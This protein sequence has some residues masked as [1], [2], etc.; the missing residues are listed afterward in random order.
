MIV[1]VAKLA[2]SPTGGTPYTLYLVHEENGDV[3]DAIRSPHDG[4]DAQALAALAKKWKGSRLPCPPDP[5]AA[6]VPLG[7]PPGEPPPA[8]ARYRAAHA[9]IRD[10]HRSA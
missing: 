6:G 1:F 2:V 3:A 7:F 10:G 9:V 8:A 5:A 4:G